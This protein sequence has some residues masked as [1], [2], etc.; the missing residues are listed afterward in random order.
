MT[1]E[2]LDPA[3]LEALGE[4]M[5]GGTP[6]SAALGVRIVSVKPGEAVM[7][8]PHRAE[9]V[10]DPETGVL[11]GG[12]V[13]TLLDHV[14]G[15]AVSSKLVAA[16]TAGPIATLDLRIDYM[17]AAEPG[18]DLMARAICYHIT[19]SIAFVRATAFDG[20]EENPVATAQAAFAL[21]TGPGPEGAPTR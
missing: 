12:V 16:G 8:L 19:H 7:A 11:A 18:H 15:L 4:R 10:G 17:R 20:D 3:V 2:S 5:A 21:G 13:T 1:Q 9:L 14:C 6:Q